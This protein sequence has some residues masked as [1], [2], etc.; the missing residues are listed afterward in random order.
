M[1]MRSET[2]TMEI[3]RK[4]SSQYKLNTSEETA[5]TVLLLVAGGKTECS[6]PVSTLAELC[7][8][9][10]S[11]VRRAIRSLETKGLVQRE[12]QYYN[13]ERTERAANKFILSLGR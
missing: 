2:K 7:G 13:E 12:A 4:I 8:R 1:N 9:S 11:H 6:L 5:F 3:I 10:A